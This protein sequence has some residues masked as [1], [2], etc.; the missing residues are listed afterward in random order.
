MH[1]ILIL[2]A[3]SPASL[4]WARLLT[5]A[6]YRVHSADSLHFAPSRFS[7][8]SVTFTCLPKPK[9]QP[10]QWLQQLLQ[11]LKR[12][13]IDAIIPT[14]EEVFY[15]A[16]A[17]TLI[18]QAHP[19]Q[20]F[21]STIALLR[22]LHHKGLFA[23]MTQHWS[24]TTP[25]TV[26][27]TDQLSFN[28]FKQQQFIADSQ[29]VFKPAFSRFAT[30]TLLCPK[31]IDYSE[32]QACPQYPW[33]A[34]QFISGKEYC[35]YSIIRHGQIIAHSCYH[36]K[37]RIGQGAGIYF[38][39]VN[40]NQIYQFVE[41]FATQTKYHGQVGF[42]FIQDSNGEIYVIECNPR[43]TSGIHFLLQLPQADQTNIIHAALNP[44][45]AV[46]LDQLNMQQM[47]PAMHNWG[48][49]MNPK[50]SRS[51]FKKNFWR[52]FMHAHD[53]MWE[54]KDMLP[55]LSQLFPTAEFLL[56]AMAFHTDPL[57]ATTLDIEWDGTPV[58]FG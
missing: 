43:A 48:M 49:L 47:L 54:R 4:T 5:K 8:Y 18:Q 44:D 52:D 56:R 6:G 17:Q 45:R 11:L 39:P 57:S 31:T 28:T 25:E 40:E 12:E 58:S 36:P 27:L 32:L 13:K 1:N 50:M 7:R 41:H 19:C 14:C 37:Y 21:T 2:G 29:W 30:K 10:K 24:L 22:Q 55:S 9:Q 33:V 3:R 51:W 34:Q 26:L 42:D 23:Q 16:S 35:S 15:L 38:E 53:V 20:L 46:A